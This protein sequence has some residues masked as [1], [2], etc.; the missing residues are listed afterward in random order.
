MLTMI[1]SPK[2]KENPMNQTAK[3]S[4]RIWREKGHA[5]PSGFLRE[6]PVNEDHSSAS[7]REKEDHV[8]GRERRQKIRSID[9]DIKKKE[10]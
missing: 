3:N 9:P 1:Q 10:A 7:P 4:R 5:S 8:R 6:D 2:K